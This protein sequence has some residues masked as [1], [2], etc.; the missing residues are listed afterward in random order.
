M[1]AKDPESLGRQ[2]WK[3]RKTAAQNKRERFA[4]C[5]QNLQ[6]PSERVICEYLRDGLTRSREK[7]SRKML[8]P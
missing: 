1:E 2:I 3:K 4:G 5:L 8:C 7:A 6:N